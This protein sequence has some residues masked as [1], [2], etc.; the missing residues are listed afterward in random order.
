M[1]S[2]DGHPFEALALPHLETIY[3]VARRRARHVHAAEDLVQ[4]TYLKAY[5]AFE[6]FEVR[7][8]GIKP[9]LSRILNNTFLNRLARERKAPR[10]TDHQ[11]LEAT[12][13]ADAV[14]APQELDSQ[15]VDEEVKRAIDGLVPEFPS[16]L[17]LWATME[18]SYQEIADIPEVPIGTVMNRLHGAGQQ[19]ARALNEYARRRGLLKTDNEPG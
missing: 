8:Y 7:E 9:W 13:E 19:R 4:E 1:G 5:R 14:E 12:Q 11:I 3:R 15:H 6:N 17:L 16:T 18:H 10:P 2:P